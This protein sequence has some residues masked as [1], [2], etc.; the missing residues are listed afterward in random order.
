[1]KPII[2][3]LVL[4][5][6]L[7]GCATTPGPDEAAANNLS[8]PKYAVWQ[9]KGRV[10]LTREEQ[11]WHGSLNW[12]EASGRYR[13]DLSGPLGQ[14]AL[15]IDGGGDTV[16]LKTANG[17]EHTAQDVDQLIASVTGWHLPV[18]GIRFWIRGIPAPGVEARVLTDERGR[19]RH[20]EQA[21]WDINYER[22]QRVAGRDWPTKMR[23][24][25]ADISVRLVVD[26]W[27]LSA[28]LDP[29]HPDASITAP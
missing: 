12:R 16:R 14:G 17:E 11:G 8:I 2:P 4:A 3:G 26:E 19:L 23:L 29:Q 25:T 20:L 13:L 9:F 6:V 28:S 24:T 10:S 21:G 7:T 15:Q 5:L 18:T 22:Y 27:I 1:M